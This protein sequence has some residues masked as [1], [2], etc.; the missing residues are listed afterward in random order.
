M[1]FS[2]YDAVGTLGVGLIVIAYGLLQSGRMRAETPLYSL[3]N[4]LG[5]ILILVSLAVDFNF[6][7]VLMEGI[8]LL[9]SL[10]G[11]WRVKYRKPPP[12]H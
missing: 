3:L 11:L 8:W 9:L 2:W 5:A 6:S 10:Y 7:A 12:V 1:N 4:A